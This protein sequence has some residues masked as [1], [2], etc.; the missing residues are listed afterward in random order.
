MGAIDPT[1]VHAR[2]QE[3]VL[4]AQI[5]AMGD[6]LFRPRTVTTHLVAGCL[7]CKHADPVLWGLLYQV[8]VHDEPVV[9]DFRDSRVYP[10][11]DFLPR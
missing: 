2:H 8:P 5:R 3:D 9:V 4:A 7:L 11:I 1:V 10:Y 6:R